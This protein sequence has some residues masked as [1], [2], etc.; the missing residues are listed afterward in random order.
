MNIVYRRLRD[1]DGNEIHEDEWHIADPSADVARILC[2]GE[3]I[4]G[5]SLV[6]LDSKEVKRGG[7]TCK[8]CL[9]IIKDFKAIRL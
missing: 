6:I 3:A 1:D 7:I 5:D 8:K 2:T 9:Q 4:D